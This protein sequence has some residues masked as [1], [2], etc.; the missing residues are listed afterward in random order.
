RVFRHRDRVAEIE[1]RGPAR[2]L[3]RFAG[4]FAVSRLLVEMKPKF[5]CEL[6]VLP[7]EREPPQQSAD[8][9]LHVS[10][11]DTGFSTRHIA[12]ENASH[13]DSSPTSCFRPAG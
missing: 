11:R 7:F 4:I 3:R 12:R 9:R 6:R 13:F 2:G 5:F 10:S 1:A 8:E